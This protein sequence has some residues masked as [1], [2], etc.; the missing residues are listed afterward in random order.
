[1]T[2]GGS[3][4]RS[5]VSASEIEN[6]GEHPQHTAHAPHLHLVPN[7]APKPAQRSTYA[8]A[9]AERR[10][11]VLRALKEEGTTNTDWLK[12]KN[13]HRNIGTHTLRPIVHLGES[14]IPEQ[15]ERHPKPMLREN[16]PARILAAERAELIVWMQNYP[17]SLK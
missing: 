6:R 7:P 8:E 1:M 5:F 11:E 17:E 4:A 15:P 9:A 14:I 2:L 13:G 16:T 10:A 3:T 12:D